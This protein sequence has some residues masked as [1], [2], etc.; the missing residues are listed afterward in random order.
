[1]LLLLLPRQLLQLL[2]LEES[3]N[4]VFICGSECWMTQLR[5]HRAESTAVA[6]Q[7]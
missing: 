7:Q 3:Q 1:M 6:V 5:L 4:C 2:L